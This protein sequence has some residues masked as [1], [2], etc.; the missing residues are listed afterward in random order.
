MTTDEATAYHE[1]GHVVAGYFSDRMPKYAT[2]VPDP[3][4]DSLGHCAHPPPPPNFRP[5]IQ[6]TPTGRDR[7]ERAIVGMAGGHIA[8]KRYRG[9]ANLHGSSK[10][11]L[12]IAYLISYIAGPDEEELYLKLLWKRAETLINMRW[13]QVGAVACALIEQRKLHRDELQT[14]IRE[15]MMAEIAHPAETV[16]RRSS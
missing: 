11:R 8:E 6:I 1:A 3:D 4:G 14:V 7:L 16:D 13:A 5:D 12:N 15:S 10:D 2:I 9:R